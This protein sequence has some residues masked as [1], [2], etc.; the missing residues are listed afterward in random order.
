[1]SFGAVLCVLIAPLFGP[2]L[3]FEPIQM[4]WVNL[5][6]DGRPVMALGV[7][8]A[9]PGIMHSITLSGQNSSIRAP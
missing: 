2:P 1:M 8:P 7:D 4:L 6:M 3:P 9:R 5:I